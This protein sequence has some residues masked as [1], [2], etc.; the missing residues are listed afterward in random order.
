[1]RRLWV[2]VVVG[3]TLWPATGQPAAAASFALTEREQQEAI[4]LGR[5]SVVHEQIGGEWTSRNG[6]GETLTVVTPFHR[7]AL[8]ARNA[9]FKKEPLK[10][11]EIRAVL[12]E[13]TGKLTVWVTLRGVTADFARF[14]EPA[15]R[16]GKAEIKPSFVQNERTAL[17]GE[18]GRY[19]ARCLYVFDAETLNP[20]GRFTLIVRDPDEKEVSKFTLDLSAMR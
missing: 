17:R 20:K 2:L 14:F 19:A 6:S 4:R 7:L 16:D 12:K 18:D 1:M 15:L 13:T 10:P 8:A 9:A 5:K 11:R 3:V